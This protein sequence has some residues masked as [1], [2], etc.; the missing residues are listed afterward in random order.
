MTLRDL[1]DGPSSC[2]PRRL[3]TFKDIG[4][5]STT[6]AEPA[7]EAAR[8]KKEQDE[9]ASFAQVKAKEDGDAEKKEGDAEEKPKMPD[10]EKVH[11]LEPVEYKEKA[12]T[13]T[14]W[15]RTTFYDKK[16]VNKSQI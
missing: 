7:E 5:P 1:G 13:N 11:V 2:L 14:P 4:S 15:L 6:A 8:A 3:A 9:K 16:N 12:D 10:P